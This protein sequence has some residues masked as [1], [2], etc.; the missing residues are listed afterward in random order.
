MSL[1]YLQNQ[2]ELRKLPLPGRVEKRTVYCS[3]KLHNTRFRLNKNGNS[4]EFAANAFECINVSPYCR[5]RTST[6][7][8]F[9]RDDGI[10]STAQVIVVITPPPRRAEKIIIPKYWNDILVRYGYLTIF[11]KICGVIY[12]PNCHQLL[13]LLLHIACCAIL[14]EKE[15][16]SFREA[17]LGWL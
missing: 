12:A 5:T 10:E 9:G 6:A 17:R 14:A 1:I 3:L 13:L 16:I 15:I 4:I 8:D 7:G 2:N 11:I